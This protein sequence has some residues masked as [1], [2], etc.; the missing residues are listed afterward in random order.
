MLKLWK[1]GYG[2]NEKDFQLLPLHNAIGTEL[3]HGHVNLQMY[4]VQ[5]KEI[6][7]VKKV[8]LFNCDY[9]LF[10]HFLYVKK[11]RHQEF[12]WDISVVSLHLFS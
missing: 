7:S 5:Q 10:H 1:I 8:C 4:L 2:E 11:Y 3:I 9:V 6:N 12:I